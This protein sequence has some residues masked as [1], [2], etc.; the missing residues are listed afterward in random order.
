MVSN[1]ISSNQIVDVPI[2]I[3]CLDVTCKDLN[4][5]LEAIIAKVCEPIDFSELNFGCLDEVDNQVDL[6]QQLIDKVCEVT[7][8][9]GITFNPELLEYCATDSWICGE[10]ACLIVENNCDPGN[11]TLENVLQAIISRQQTIT[12]KLTEICGRLDS[13]EGQYTSLNNRITQIENT[14]C[15]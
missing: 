13:L 14:C 12:E 15:Q 6:Y 10:E 5:I 2:N 3:G 7:V 8:D 9:Q 4:T 11:I 1:P